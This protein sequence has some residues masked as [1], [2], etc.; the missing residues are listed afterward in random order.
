MA[1]FRTRKPDDIEVFSRSHYRIQFHPDSGKDER[2]EVIL[3]RDGD[4]WWL[5]QD[6]EEE[7]WCYYDE[8]D[9]NGV[10][11]WFDDTNQ[12]LFVIRGIEEASE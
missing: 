12:E 8:D 5:K 4:T 6:A 10:W 3:R 1:V 2:C 9:E 7:C 11:T